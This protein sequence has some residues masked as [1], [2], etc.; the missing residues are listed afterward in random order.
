MPDHSGTLFLSRPAEQAR[1]SFLADDKIISSSPLNIYNLR[2]HQQG[3][4]RNWSASCRN[5][6]TQLPLPP[7]VSLQQQANPFGGAI[8]MR[9][10]LKKACRMT[11]NTGP[12]D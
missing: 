9:G 7:T 11:T 12:E 8:P 2:S 5:I 3:S 4:S 1:L 6:L 10:K